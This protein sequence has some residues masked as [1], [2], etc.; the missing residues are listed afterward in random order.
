MNSP[1]RI[2]LVP[3]AYYPHV[4]GVEE[5]TRQ[6]ARALVRRGDQ[7]RVITNEWPAG[8]RRAEVAEGIEVR[9]LP[10]PLPQGS[11]VGLLHFGLA[12]PS[13]AGSFVREIRR[14]APDVVHV[15]GA[16]PPAVYAAV[17][18]KLVRAPMVFTAHGELTYDAHEAFRRS[19][20]L[21]YGLR[22]MLTHASVVTACSRAV[23]GDLEHF[24]HFPGAREVIP[25]GVDPDE[26]SNGTPPD[27]AGRYILAVGRLVPQKGFDILLRAFTEDSLAGLSLVIAG[28][29]PDRVELEAKARGL[30]LAERVE[31][32]GAVERAR[33]P[34]LLAGARAFA[35]PSRGEAFGLALLEAMAAGVP[36]VAAAAGG[37]PELAVDGQNALLVEPENAPQLARALA[38]LDADRELRERLAAGGRAT[39]DQLRWD[40][41][42]QRYVDLYL[43]VSGR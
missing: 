21:R 26:F 42:C 5:V 20:T 25:N 36:A 11:A 16:G 12:A 1:L 10:F 3:S 17:L 38:R 8:V 41:V 35:F 15:M 19:A 13:A 18:R 34:S 37:I 29:G 27:S 23:L 33:L 6:L 40:G 39:A 4:G 43:R 32:L 7:P 28:E 30:G 22:S 31:F 14:A 24:S 2:L 9:R